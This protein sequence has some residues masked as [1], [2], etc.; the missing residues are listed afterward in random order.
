[1]LTPCHFLCV[2]GYLTFHHQYIDW[3]QVKHTKLFL[4]IIFVLVL[5][6]EEEG[7]EGHSTKIV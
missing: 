6:V 2:T 5:S 4:L 7:G 3:I 1:M